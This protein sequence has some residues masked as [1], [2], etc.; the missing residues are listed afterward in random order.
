MKCHFHLFLSQC[1]VVVIFPAHSD[2]PC[3]S[4]LVKTLLRT[5][6]QIL[7]TIF[8]LIACF[9]CVLVAQTTR[10]ALCIAQLPRSSP[11]LTDLSWP[12]PVL[13]FYRNSSGVLVNLFVYHHLPA[14]A[15]AET[16][17]NAERRIQ[18]L[19]PI[20]YKIAIA[21]TRHHLRNLIWPGLVAS[22]ATTYCD[23][24][25]Q[26][27]ALAPACGKGSSLL[28]AYLRWQVF[29]LVLAFEAEQRMKFTHLLSV[30]S[31]LRFLVPPPSVRAL[32]HRGNALWTLGLN[33]W[34]GVNSNFAFMPRFLAHAFMALAFDELT[35]GRV[36]AAGKAAVFAN[37][38][39]ELVMVSLRAYLDSAAWSLC[40]IPSTATLQ[41]CTAT[42]EEVC[43]YTYGC[44]SSQPVNQ[45]WSVAVNAHMQQ[46]GYSD[47]HVPVNTVASAKVKES[48]DVV[49]SNFLKKSVWEAVAN[50]DNLPCYAASTPVVEAD[51][52]VV[53]AG[54][55]GLSAAATLVEQGFSVVLL[56]AG[57][58][59]ADKS[60][61]AWSGKVESARLSPLWSGLFAGQTSL[62]WSPSSMH[63]P[64]GTLTFTA[65]KVVGGTGALN[66]MALFAGPRNTYDVRS[67]KL[68][69]F[70]S[71][72]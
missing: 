38:A 64:N 11:D 58:A 70:D 44:F 63:T 24:R 40:H 16:W 13:P 48:L 30:R 10:I 20:R 2:A 12:W 72:P 27:S 18:A 47:L 36:H 35:S 53:G 65:G 51:Y 54:S 26:F 43:T 34:G 31:E 15:S 8:I 71:L 56:D 14:N 17:T 69:I 6:K 41:C 5:K 68:C 19:N 28:E 60:L 67:R 46:C 42:A 50:D 9:A 4:N 29:A 32:T 25:I 22:H 1:S 21:P 39:E 52:V 49:H 45:T 7:T 3:M 61:G 55:G 57:A 59:R 37:N 66:M 33:S 23:S 62:R